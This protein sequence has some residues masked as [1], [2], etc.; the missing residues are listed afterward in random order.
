MSLEKIASALTPPKDDEDLVGWRWKVWS[1]IMF[2]LIA[3]GFYMVAAS[4]GIP[5]I[6]GFAHADDIQGVQDRLGRLEAKQNV[7]LRLQLA[8]EI[9]RVFRQRTQEENVV[10][11]RILD[12]AFSRLQEDYASVNGGLRYSVGECAD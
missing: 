12:D 4:G 3:G 6:G 9:C 7:V 11:R 10:T 5:G 8:A 1:A 2:I